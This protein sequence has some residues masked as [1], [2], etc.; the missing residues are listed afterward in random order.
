MPFSIISVVNLEFEFVK[1]QK[2]KMLAN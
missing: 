1:M 2:S